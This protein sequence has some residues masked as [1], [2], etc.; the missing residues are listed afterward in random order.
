MKNELDELM[1]PF[2]DKQIKKRVAE[3]EKCCPNMKIKKGEEGEMWSMWTRNRIYWFSWEYVEICEEVC[4]RQ[5]IS[6]YESYI[7]R[8][9]KVSI[10]YKKQTE[11]IGNIWIYW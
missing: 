2:C 3:I 5:K 10:D 11:S 8:Y 1:C 6:Y 9:Q 7:Y 4:L